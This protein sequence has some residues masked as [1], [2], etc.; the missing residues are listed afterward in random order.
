MINKNKWKEKI[1]ILFIVILIFYSVRINPL[2]LI[3]STNIFP[4]INEVRTYINQYSNMKSL[5]SQLSLSNKFKR[6]IHNLILKYNVNKK[7]RNVKSIYI[8][9]N[10]KFGNLIIFLN[11]ILFY[12]EIIG[13]EY[14]ILN[15]KKFWFIK[16]DINIKSKN[17]TIKKGNNKDFKRSVVLYYKPWKIYSNN[18]FNIK[19][20]IKIHFLRNEII[21]NLP[22]I[23]TSREEL[24]IHIRSGDIFKNYFHSNYAQPP[25]CFYSK[26]LKTFKF[27]KVIIIAKDSYNIVAEK[28]IKKFPQIVFS[29]NDMK[30]DISRLLNA[31]NIVCSISSFVITILQMNYKFEFLWDY[32]LYKN[33]EKMN[34]FHFDFNKFPHNNF[35]IF[36]MEPSAIYKKKMYNWKHSKSQQKLM[37]KD[38][39]INDFTIIKKEN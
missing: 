31:F 8:D 23:I 27:Q 26:L 28:L 38:K 30:I 32:N 22:K 10:F 15:G 13:C 36:R 12:C 39:C 37:I 19:T 4:S 1:L 2:K 24:Y 35:T 7:N 9:V 6:K 33:T 3:I 14:L 20:P 18:I 25:L 29:Q 21:N 34:H 5:D 17:I 16:N 11:K